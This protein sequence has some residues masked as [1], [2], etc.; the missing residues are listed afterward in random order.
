MP[1]GL[2]MLWES[3]EPEAALEERFG[4][5][6]FGAAT[7]WVSAVLEQIWGLTA[8]ECS[9]MAI[10]DQNAIVWVASDRGGLVVKWSRAT[11]RF[12]KLEA[13]TRLL[14]TLAGQ[15]APVPSPIT[16]LNGLDRETLPAWET[17]EGPSCAVSFTV[18]PE[19]AGDWLDVQDHAAVRSAGA[20]LAEI[21]RTL[22]ATHVDGSVF[23]S[24]STG[25]KERIGGW[26]ENFDRGFAPEATRRLVYLLA[27]VP[28]LDDQTQLVHNDF[29]AANILTRNSQTTGVLDFD[30]VVIDH[31][32]SDL[33]KACVYLG[34]LFTD[35]RPTPIAV[36]QSLRAGYESVRPLSRSE[37][38]WFEILELWH[39]LMAIP[40]ENDTAG[41]A[42][43]L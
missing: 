41:W 31:R 38:E 22:G 17:L 28:E 19:L 18:L 23:S 1:L 33:A 10:S 16:S 4:F 43:A 20:C 29:R 34:T 39:G 15:G 9:R 30:D 35:W 26:L 40:G 25:L 6:S 13:S 27:R 8:L 37:T 5:N 32:V 3:V 12:P 7:H 14:S 2:S 36:R 11:A 24:R 21:H 42:S